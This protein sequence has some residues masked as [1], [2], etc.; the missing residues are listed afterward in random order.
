MVFNLIDNAIKFS[1]AGQ[2]IG[3]I[4]SAGERTLF[5]SVSDLGRGIPVQVLP[6]IFEPFFRVREGDGD[7]P[8][9]GLGLSICKRVI[10]GMGGVIEVESPITGLQGTRMTVK[11]PIPADDGGTPSKFSGH[12]P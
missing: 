1:S 11:L 10:E 2:S 12:R 7:V 4:V 9:T 3:V 8:G 6:R 5:L